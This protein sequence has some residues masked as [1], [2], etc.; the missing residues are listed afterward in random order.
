VTDLAGSVYSADL[1]GSNVRT[2]LD[3]QGNLTGIAYAELPADPTAD[4]PVPQRIDT[5][6][7]D[8]TDSRSELRIASIELI[9]VDLPTR[10]SHQLAMA[11]MNSQGTGNQYVGSAY[12]EGGILG[13][14]KAYAKTVR[15]DTKE[16]RV[17]LKGRPNM[18]NDAQFSI[19]QTLPITLDRTEVFKYETLHKRKLG[20]RAHGLNGN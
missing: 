19:L 9:I 13:R 7:P 20:T 16:L 10:R 12:G 11:T 8:E 2:L 18:A 14:W 15:G 3:H 1:D 4:C 6:P 5:V 17:L